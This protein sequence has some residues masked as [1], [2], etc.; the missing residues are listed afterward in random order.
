MVSQRVEEVDV[1][2]GGSGRAEGGGAEVGLRRKPGPADRPARRNPQFE[3]MLCRAVA[4]RLLVELRYD[5]E[6]VP[7]LFAPH[8]VYESTTGR[9]NVAGTQ[10][11]NPNQPDDAFEPRIFEV[12]LI[13][14]LRLTDTSFRPD[15]RF[16]PE[17]PRFHQ[18]VICSV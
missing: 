13:R 8:L 12:G 2:R 18:R 16:S 11:E 15:A 9:V 4:E 17:E 3:G 10:V 5:S 1:A 7:R 14:T 6:V